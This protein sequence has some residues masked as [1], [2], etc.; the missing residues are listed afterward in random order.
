LLAVSHAHAAITKGSGRM[1]GFHRTL[2]AAMK[3]GRATRLLALGA[4]AATVG[5]CSY[6][7]S[8][9]AADASSADGP[10]FDAA[11]DEGTTADAS[12]DAPPVDAMRE[13]THGDGSRLDAGADCAALGAAIAVDRAAA[14]TCVYDPSTACMTTAKDECGCDVVV[15]LPDSGADRAFAAAVAALAAAGCTPTCAGCTTVTPGSCL[16]VDAGGGYACYEGL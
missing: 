13:A 9:G 1:R 6:D 5:A 15:G 16:E 10:L 4:S 14:I 12:V 11:V 3:A 7:W 2:G 8:L